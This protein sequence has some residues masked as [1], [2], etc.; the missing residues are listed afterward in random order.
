MISSALTNVNARLSKPPEMFSS[1][2]RATFVWPRR[3]VEVPS[4]A[5]EMPDR[6]I[7]LPTLVW[8]ALI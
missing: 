1:L 7:V 2:T 6:L 3:R 4:K 5:A 8:A